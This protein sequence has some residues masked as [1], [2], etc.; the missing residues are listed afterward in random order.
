MFEHS[1]S[2][3]SLSPVEGERVIAAAVLDP[4]NA[5]SKRSRSVFGLALELCGERAVAP[6]LARDLGE[7]PLR[8]VDVA[9]H[10]GQG[11]RRFRH[12]AVLVQCFA[13]HE[14]FHPSL[15]SALKRR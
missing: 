6:D 3:F 15:I 10:L 9:L 12:P 14:S 13:S 2:T 1:A 5:R 11:D 8:V 7:A 4:Q